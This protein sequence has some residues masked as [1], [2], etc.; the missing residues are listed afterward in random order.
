MTRDGLV[1][2]LKKESSIAAPMVAVSVLQYLLQVVSLVIV[3]HLGTLPLSSVAIATSLTNV[4]G[5]SLLSGMVGGLETLCGQAYGAKEYKKLGT[6]TYSA[7][8][9]LLILC[10][11]ICLLWFF[12]DR[13]LVFAGQDEAIA[14]QARDFSMWLIPGLFGAA[15]LKPTTRFLQTQS[16]IFPMLL[17][18]SLVLCFHVVACWTLVYKLGIGYVGAAMAISFST[19]LNVL[20]LACY[21][22]LSPVCERTR[23]DLTGEAFRGVKQFFRLGISS[24]LMVCLKWWSMELLILLSGLLSNPKLETSVLSICLSISTLHFTVPYGLG[25]AVSTRVSNELG[26]G[27]PQLARTAVV[28]ATFLAFTESVIVIAVLFFCR[29][30]V[31]YAF[32]RDAH[33]VHYVATMIPLLCLSILTDS[34]QA[35]LS[36]VARGC[37]WQ[38]VGAYINL[39]SFYLVGLPLGCVL[40]FVAHLKG[41]GLWV[42][43]VAGSL[44]QAA[45]LSIFTACLD[46]EK[47][48]SSWESNM[49]NFTL[50]LLAFI[51]MVQ[52]EVLSLIVML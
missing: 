37:G 16:V 12:M 43:I 41:K 47:Q 33:I 34:F 40:G 26:G 24:A 39:G 18:S 15:I 45:S 35:I 17:S 30:F 20:L 32:S 10:P 52:F 48:V 2:E 1:S 28:V 13:F 21:V 51:F 11:P 5:F 27:R 23:G 25:A 46:W 4:T 29:R 22:R 50:V 36:G 6:Y 49:S 8:I 19:W 7:I 14:H 44:V 3:G 9:T 38:H 31:G 42:G